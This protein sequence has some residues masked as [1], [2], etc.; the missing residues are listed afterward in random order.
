MAGLLTIVGLTAR[1]FDLAGRDCKFAFFIS[2]WVVL[3]LLV[4]P[5]D[6]TWRES[7]LIYDNK[8]LSEPTVS[9]YT[10]CSDVQDMGVI[11]FPLYTQKRVR[12]LPQPELNT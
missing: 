12:T 11:H 2:S 7:H 1:L 10:L 8:N 9:I 5:E 6:H 3:L 4:W